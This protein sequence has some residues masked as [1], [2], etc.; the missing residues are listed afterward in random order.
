MG[1]L[2]PAPP[3]PALLVL[4]PP[5]PVTLELG[6]APLPDSD[7]AA[8]RPSEQTSNELQPAAA[9][10]A[11]QKHESPPNNQLEAR[12]TDRPPQKLP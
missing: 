8:Q 6:P 5:V 10:S 2:P 11:A 9:P 1:L 3:P 7:A 12:M 4:L